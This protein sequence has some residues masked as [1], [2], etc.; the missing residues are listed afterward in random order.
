MGCCGHKNRIATVRNPRGQPQCLECAT[1]H[2]GKAMVADDERAD[3]YDNVFYI[4]GNMGLAE[5]HTLR[6]PELHRAI[7]E[8]RKTWQADRTRPD[9]KRLEELTIAAHR[10]EATHAPH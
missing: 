3:G 5:D 7:R 2:L 1:K 9:W 6:W 4:T 10:T 8:A